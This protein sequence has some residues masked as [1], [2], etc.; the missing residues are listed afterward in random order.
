MPEP[1]WLQTKFSM[2]AW[3]EGLFTD[4]HSSRFVTWYDKY[5]IHEFSWSASYLD[6]VDP[7]IC[8]NHVNPII[9]TQVGP[10]DGEVIYLEVLS[11]VKDD[12]KL[13]A[14][15]ENEVVNRS[16]DGW[17][18]SDKTGTESTWLDISISQLSLCWRGRL[19]LP[20]FCRCIPVPEWHPFHSVSKTQ[21]RQL[22]TLLTNRRV[23]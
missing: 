13:W 19:T 4:T 8:A 9:R 6:I 1:A 10:S 18:Y 2:R 16:V 11:K 15:N 22:V 5:M 20:S 3:L 23:E 12:V 14:V 7:I 17:N 21:S